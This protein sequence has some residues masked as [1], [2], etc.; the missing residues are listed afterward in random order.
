MD[1]SHGFLTQL[2]LWAVPIVMAIMLHEVMHGVVARML[3]DD[4]A[5]RAG[6]LTLNPLAHIDP[7]GTIILPALL[8]FA[9]APVFGYAKPVPVDFR[10]LHPPRAGMIAVAA[11]GPLTNFTLAIL[12]GVAFR[13]LISTLAPG[14]TFT[15][16]GLLSQMALASCIVNLELAVFNLLP[17]LPLDGGRVL[18]GLLPPRLALPFAR[19]ER[20]GFLILLLLLYTNM[21]NAV[22]DPVINAMARVLL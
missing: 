15:L 3:G 22:V 8:L 2:L 21:V 10:Q 13:H 4:T 12:S 7:F 18:A 9:H 6:R 17:L 1:G 5:A 11:A 16:R 19:L 20:Y 14:A